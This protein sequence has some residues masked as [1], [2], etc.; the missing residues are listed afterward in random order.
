MQ[1]LGVI[2]KRSFTVADSVLH[3][4]RYG[5]SVSW[6]VLCW[7][8]AWWGAAC[9]GSARLYG[10]PAA[11]P[12]VS[13]ASPSVP[14]IG[15]RSGE[16]AGKNLVPSGP[17]RLQGR[18]KEKVFEGLLKERALYS[19]AALS[20]TS[21]PQEKR[22][23]FEAAMVVHAPWQKVQAALTNYALYP[24]LISYIESADF[25]ERTQLLRIQGGIWNFVLIS[26][27]S[28]RKKH[29]QWIELEVVS[30]HFQGLRG[31]MSFEALENGRT[32]VF[33]EG[34]QVGRKWP[35][36]FII[37]RG[38]EVVFEFTARKMRSYIEAMKD[39]DSEAGAAGGG[40]ELPQ[41]RKRSSS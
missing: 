2:W 29:P 38:A 17:P 9:L 21:I 36:K 3:L 27:V 24:K 11:V 22:Y 6:R 25:S 13:I 32:G 31:S 23:Q 10:A 16:G 14:M 35:P 39:K 37:E 34:S 18:L 7:G 20:E 19:K 4:N 26:W 5:R 28:F 12:S 8:V 40:S 41:P 30:G 1:V 15:L 33:F